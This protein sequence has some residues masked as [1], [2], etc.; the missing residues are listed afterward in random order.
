MLKTATPS[1]DENGK[2]KSKGKEKKSINPY[3]GPLGGEHFPSLLSQPYDTKPSWISADHVSIGDQILAN[4]KPTSISPLDFDYVRRGDVT[5]P[6]DGLSLISEKSGIVDQAKTIIPT[7]NEII[8]QM[9]VLSTVRPNFLGDINLPPENATKAEVEE[10]KKQMVETNE[11]VEKLRK[12]MEEAK[13]QKL[14]LTR[15]DK[16]RIL[17][18]ILPDALYFADL[19]SPTNTRDSEL[20]KDF[21]GE[22]HKKLRLCCT[23]CGAFVKEV[24]TLNELRQLFDSQRKG[25]PIQCDDKHKIFLIFAQKHLFV[26]G[27]A[28]IS[29]GDIRGARRKE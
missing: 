14:E 1:S 13:N 16:F 26:I 17:L 5:V 25:N 4:T 19:Y 23:I 11:R 7:A 27:S 6:T 9:D 21:F 22:K 28:E 8:N 15:E 2:K 18:E 10:T 3:L 24:K 12:S 29:D 20:L